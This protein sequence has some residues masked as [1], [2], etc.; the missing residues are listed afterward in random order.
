MSARMTRLVGLGSA[1]VATLLVL[2]AAPGGA[3]ATTFCVPAFHVACPDNGTNVAEADLQTALNA[4]SNDGQADAIFVDEGTYTDDTWTASD[5]GGD[6]LTIQGAGRAE[7]EL[8][9]N[10]AANAYVVNLGA[11]PTV[12]RDLTVAIPAIKTPHQAPG[13]QMQN[14]VFERVDIVTRVADATAVPSVVGNGSAFRE[15]TVYAENG[16]SFYHGFRLSVNLGAGDTFEIEDATVEAANAIGLGAVGNLQGGTI[17]VA[18]S[19]VN[20]ETS[21]VA[22]GTGVV[23]VENAQL[24][25]EGLPL[26]ITVQDSTNATINADHTSMLK[27]GAGSVA[28]ASSSVTSTNAGT[29][30]INVTNAATQGYD[31]KHVRQ[32]TAA[33]GAANVSFA[34]S[35]LPAADGTSVGQGTATYGA[36]IT[37]HA[38]AGFLA[39]N[40]LALTAGSPMIDAADPASPL[41]EDIDGQPRP[42]DGDGVGGARS[43]MGAYEYP[44]TPDVDP[45]V[46]TILSGPEYG[47]LIN[48]ASPSFT[49][50][51]S[52]PGTFECN[53]GDGFAPCTSPHQVGPLSD[54]EHTFTV[55]AVDNASNVDPSPPSR[56]FTVDT[57]APTVTIT[58]GPA[59]GS[60]LVSKNATFAFSSS[61]PGP[62][63]CR[64]DN[65]TFAPCG[66]PR[67]FTGL[68]EG[69]HT[70]AVRATDDAGN[71]GAATTR[72]FSVDTTP[73][74]TTI[75]AGPGKRAK[76]GKVR[77]RFASSEPGSSFRC[78]LDKKPFT[79]C[80]SPFRKKK[81]KPGRHR[82]QVV[83]IDAVGNADPTAASKRFKVKKKKKKKKRAR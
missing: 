49:F 37:T 69:P 45:P 75:T 2:L 28:V 21:G 83:A 46:T 62:I 40:N 67:S 47:G 48:D 70:F 17:N 43:D 38:D 4:D 41:A 56:A 26:A 29:A 20:F 39:P 51:S 55:R 65:A 33:N 59:E 74:E 31:F 25:G 68:A 16:G 15:G 1:F 27:T 77:F 30:A 54:G 24:L 14:D 44:D 8:T 12:V 52:E 79:A 64:L 22:I 63:E 5:L 6:P 50:S 42:I 60:V 81:L 72:S 71:E 3:A 18:R 76:R 13:V 53:I 80:T 82:F 32:G 11:R 78:R 58:G 34:Y 57:E 10:S 61:E 36:G 7:T 9:S 35:N 66:S 73:P 19:R 23:N